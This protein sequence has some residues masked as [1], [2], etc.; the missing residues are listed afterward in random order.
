MDS[1][2]ELPNQLK[3][4]NIFFQLVSVEVVSVGKMAKH[5]ELCPKYII[6][7]VPL[8]LSFMKLD[9]CQASWMKLTAGWEILIEDESKAVMVIVTIICVTANKEKSSQCEQAGVTK[10]ILKPA[11]RQEEE[12]AYQAF[13]KSSRCLCIRL[14]HLMQYVCKMLLAFGLWTFICS[15]NISCA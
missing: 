7:S 9:S 3:Y 1:K 4:F 11:R 10:P 2:L 6:G 15:V 8:K 14:L 13:D 5:R 12:P